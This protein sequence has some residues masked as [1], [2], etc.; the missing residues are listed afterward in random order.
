LYIYLDESGDLGF[1]PG[2]SKYFLIT[3]LITGN[4]RPI[5]KCIRKIR[6]SLDKKPKQLKELKA[7]HSTEVTRNRLLKCLTD[8][9]DIEIMSIPTM[10]RY[11]RQ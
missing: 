11:Y 7:Y 8:R 6:A 4:P 5:Q 2:S 9:E 10:S 1:K 3:L